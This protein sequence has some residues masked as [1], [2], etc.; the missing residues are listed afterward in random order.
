MTPEFVQQLLGR[1]VVRDFLRFAAV[2]AVATVV[3][4]AVLIAMTELGS[5]DPVWATV[6]GF[7]V[8]ALVSYTLNRLY[9]FAAKPAF[10]KGLAKYLLVIAI[11]AVINAGI[12]AA[13]VGAGFHYMIGQVIAT[14]LVLIWNFAGARLLVFR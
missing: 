11:G 7:L 9:T 8:G 4:Y 10:G 1:A 12:V 3:H 5:A 2:G 6:C 13:F 14:G